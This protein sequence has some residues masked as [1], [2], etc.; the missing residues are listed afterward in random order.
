MGFWCTCFA[1][2]LGARLQD[3]GN[4]LTLSSG[5][6][7]SAA[8]G[9]TGENEVVRSFLLVSTMEITNGDGFPSNDTLLQ[10][11]VP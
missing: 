2:E 8:L 11:E 5:V 4:S 10:L 9:A 6:K 1:V 7:E 3:R